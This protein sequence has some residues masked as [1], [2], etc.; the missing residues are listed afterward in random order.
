MKLKTLTLAFALAL[1]YA[2]AA[3]ITV[4]IV[5]GAEGQVME[6]AR[7]VAKKEYDLDVNI[8]EFDDYVT[9]NIALAD[10]SIDANAFQHGPYLDVMIKERGLKLVKVANTFVYPIAAYSKKLK[11]IDELQDGATIALPNDPT[12]GARALMLL[13]KAGYIKL[14]DGINKLEASVLDV[15][16]NPHQ[17]KLKD[18]DAPQLPRVLDEVDIAFINNTFAAPAGLVAKENGLLVEDKDS[19]YVNII[20]VRQGDENR[21]EVQDL[22]KA[23]Q[24]EEVVKKADEVFKGSAIKGW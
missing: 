7:D 18:I 3:E 2:Q 6:A 1:G 5:A 24:T 20:A 12:N 8:V 22:I 16:E 10:G 15:A 19:P 9:P 11:S 17:F 21:K 14:K 23:F 4:G 13:E